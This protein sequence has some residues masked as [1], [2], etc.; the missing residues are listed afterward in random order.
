MW[1]ASSVLLWQ[2]VHF[3]ASCHKTYKTY[4][5]YGTYKTYKSYRFS[6]RHD[7]YGC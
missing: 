2:Q 6:K 4:R 1:L 7:S 3:W 5:T